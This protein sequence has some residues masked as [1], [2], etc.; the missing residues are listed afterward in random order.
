MVLDHKPSW[1]PHNLSCTSFLK[2][3]ECQVSPQISLRYIQI[4]ATMYS[5]ECPT[6]SCSIKKHASYRRVSGM[7]NLLP[8]RLLSPPLPDLEFWTIPNRSSFGE[9]KVE[10]EFDQ[11]HAEIDTARLNVSRRPPITRA[12]LYRDTPIYTKAGSPLLGDIYVPQEEFCFN[13]SPVGSS[14]DDC[15]IRQELERPLSPMTGYLPRESLVYKP[16]RYFEIMLIF[17]SSTMHTRM[18]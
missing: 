8:L 12:R 1:T 17:P 14:Y 18:G 2:F 10:P 11:S 16:I 5:T 4:R 7:K 9:A 15:G 13:Y 3:C 6:T